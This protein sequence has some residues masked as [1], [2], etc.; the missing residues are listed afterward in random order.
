MVHPLIEDFHANAATRRAILV[1]LAD[2][3]DLSGDPVG[4]A[5]AEMQR[6]GA[7]TY[8]EGG[9]RTGVLARVV[10]EAEARLL[11][12]AFTVCEQH[13]AEVVESH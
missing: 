12:L 5:W 8:A 13:E 3:I 10:R 6:E 9:E 4:A 2:N 7:P 1:A 11:Q